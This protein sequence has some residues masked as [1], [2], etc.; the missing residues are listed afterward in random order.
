MACVSQSLA[1]LPSL[2]D[3]QLDTAPVFGPLEVRQSF[4]PAVTSGLACASLIPLRSHSPLYRGWT[5]SIWTCGTTSRG[6]K[7]TVAVSVVTR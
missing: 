4:S 2:E 3:I 6:S 5:G 1:T 7:T